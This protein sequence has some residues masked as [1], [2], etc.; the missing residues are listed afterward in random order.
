MGLQ[1]CPDTPGRHE[2]VGTIAL[3]LFARRRR[4]LWGEGPRRRSCPSAR[5]TLREGLRKT[6]AAPHRAPSGSWREGLGGGP[7]APRWTA[8]VGQQQPYL[9][10]V[11]RQRRF[12]VL[13]DTIPAW[14]RDYQMLIKP[15]TFFWRM[16][17]AKKRHRGLE[18][19]AS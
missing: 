7:L 9:F 15:L 11:S 14:P 16:L 1:D 10:L 17:L 8:S 2:C 6:T 13:Q 3:A 12:T 4:S 18:A 5:R 19:K